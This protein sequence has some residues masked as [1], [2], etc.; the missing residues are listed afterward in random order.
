MQRGNNDDDDDDDNDH[1]DDD[2]DEYD[3]C[4]AGYDRSCNSESE[5]FIGYM[6]VLLNAIDVISA[7]FKC[8]HSVNDQQYC[9]YTDGSV[10]SWDEARKFCERKY[11]TLPIIADINTDNAFQRFISDSNQVV[12]G[13]NNYVWLDAHASHD[14]VR[15]HWIKRQPSG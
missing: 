3:D 13:S 9:F 8:Y 7:F 6:L 15:W 12:S 5:C 4:V 11:S 10:M 2:D 1:D 14:S